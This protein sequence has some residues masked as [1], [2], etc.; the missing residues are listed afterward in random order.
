[1]ERLTPKQL[2]FCK[3]YLK[4]GNATTSYIA[5]GYTATNPKHAEVLGCQLLKNH[6][7]AA[8]LAEQERAA[9]A[10]SQITLKRVVEEISNLGFSDVTEVVEVEKFEQV[11]QTKQGDRT[12]KGQTVIVKDLKELPK[13]VTC[14]IQEIRQTKDGIAVKMHPKTEPL[15]KLLEYLGGL[16]DANK[17]IATLKTYGINLK[18]SEDGSWFVDNQSP[19]SNQ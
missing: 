18:Q 3:E 12:I 14:A 10:E 4:T 8:W 15:N 7:V 5:A 13:R 17:A 6:K 9:I 16:S 11:V 1:M 19:P 2:K